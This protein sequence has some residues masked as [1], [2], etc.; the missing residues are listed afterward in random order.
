MTMHF[1]CDDPVKLKK[2]FEDKAALGKKPGGISAWIVGS[3]GK[4]THV[5]SQFGKHGY[6]KASTRESKGKKYLT[7]ACGWPAG[8]SQEDKNFA[9]KEL[10]G[11]ILGTFIEHFTGSFTAAIYIDGRNK[12]R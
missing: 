9:Y 12:N 4:I 5:S 2:A 1:E 8:V 6:L 10:T 3:D 7:F 11:N